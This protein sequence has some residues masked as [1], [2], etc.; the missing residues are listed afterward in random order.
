MFLPAAPAAA[1]VAI[2]TLP[3]PVLVVPSLG[4]KFLG[5]STTTG[6]SV[7]EPDA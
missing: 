6:V 1:A 7:R 2:A 4:N 5:S 3:G